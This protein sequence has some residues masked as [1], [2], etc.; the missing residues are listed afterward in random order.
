MPNKQKVLACKTGQTTQYSGCSSI[1]VNVTEV[2]YLSVPYQIAIDN[3]SNI[4]I[5]NSANGYVIKFDSRFIYNS[6]YNLYVPSLYPKGTNGST[7]IGSPSGLVYN[8]TPA[9]LVNSISSILIV[10]TI[11]GQIMGWNGNDNQFTVMYQTTTN[12]SFY[13]MAICNNLLYVTDFYN[14]TVVVFNTSWTKQTNYSF[15]LPTGGTDYSPFGPIG[16]LKYN[17]QIIVSYTSVNYSAGLIA[18]FD[19]NGVYITILKNIYNHFYV[20]Y[21]LSLVPSSFNVSDSA[22]SICVSE[23]NTGAIYIVNVSNGNTYYL[24]C[25]SG[26]ST[27]FTFLYIT[28]IINYGKDL[29]YV[30]DYAKD[31]Q[32]LTVDNPSFGYIYYNS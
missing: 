10:S 15:Q 21:G 28:C 11:D 24:T 20:P 7:G 31:N 30:T 32:G 4:W 17:S 18:I 16:I 5:A 27:G 2:Q 1:N 8:N 3:D 29:L 9:F 25:S 12:E 14:K 23:Y 13:S 6:N 22:N 19:S 26:G